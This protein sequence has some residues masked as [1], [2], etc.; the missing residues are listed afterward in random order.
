MADR[1]G[2]LEQVGDR[3]IIGDP[4]RAGGSCLVLTAEGM[5]HHR[6]GSPGPYDLVPWSTYVDLSI[7]A[8][9]RARHATRTMGVLGALGGGAMETG[10]S[11]C[12]V[13]GL[14]R[15][16]YEEWSVNYTHHKRKYTSAQVIMVSALVR[17]VSR[18]RALHRL[19]DPE[20]LGEA[21]ARVTLLPASWAPKANRQV[22][23]IIEDL[24]T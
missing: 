15:R 14:L 7:R 1:L 19:G 11:G 17:Q 2:P 4:K 18:R 21:V 3:W 8:T 24:G 13:S 9:Y 16:P 23:E 12:S 5:E 6:P 20:W 22:G 10:R